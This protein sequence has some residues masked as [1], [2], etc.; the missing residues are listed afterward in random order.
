MGRDVLIEPMTE[1]LILWRCL[2]SG[3]LS[4]GTIEKWPSDSSIDFERYRARNVPILEKLTRTYGACAI[5]ARAGDSVVGQLRFYPMAVWD[6][7]NSGEMCLLQDFPY[8]PAED[9]A[10]TDFPP[11]E[12]IADKTL[13]IHCLMT[14]SS[15]QEKNPFQRKGVGTRMVRFLIQWAKANGWQ[16]VTVDAFEDIPIIYEIT[17]SAG[18]SFWQKL[19]FRIA[20]RH[21]HPYLKERNEFVETLEEQAESI[22]IDPDRAKD[23]IVM[24]LD[25][26]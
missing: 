25:L 26:I 15:Q 14:G 19:G 5:M 22:G 9:F 4:P 18:I 3:P 1:N 11:L 10:G 6:M 24:R 13:A 23:R 8:G 2:H 7:K 12:Q 17:G 21:P 20:D 16:H